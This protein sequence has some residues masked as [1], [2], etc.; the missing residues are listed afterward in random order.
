MNGVDVADQMRTKYNTARKSN[1]WWHSCFWFLF[2]LCIANS[3]IIQK[4]SQNHIELTR[5]G[6]VK[7][8]TMLDFRKI[9]IK[10]LIGNYREGRKRSLPPTVD[11]AG[12][13]HWPRKTAKKGRCTW[14]RSKGIPA[15]PR[16]ECSGC[17]RHLCLDCF[18]PHHEHLNM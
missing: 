4:E 12:I 8:F 18:V 3:F 9:L 2:D 15:E 6:T 14:C 1:K 5:S 11:D 7:V 10:S 13:A 17:G 16:T